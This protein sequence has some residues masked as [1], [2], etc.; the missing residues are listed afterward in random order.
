MAC[1]YRTL[2]LDRR[3]SLSRNHQLKAL[4]IIVGSCMA[5]TGCRAQQATPGPSVEFTRVP[6]ANEGGP[7]RLDVIEGRVSDARPGLRIVLF[8]RSGRWFV[9]PFADQPFTQI[10]TDSSW[11]SATHLGTEY[12][13]LLVEAGYEPP[14]S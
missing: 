5:M 7:D 10:Q 3:D 11:R 14:P 12:A 8:A 2:N 1:E 13:A 4:L 9:Q 6:L